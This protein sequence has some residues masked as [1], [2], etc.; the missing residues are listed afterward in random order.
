MRF[1][2]GGALAGAVPAAV[3]SLVF[4]V[5]R[6]TLMFRM[7]LVAVAALVFG[8]IGYSAVREPSPPA[9]GVKFTFIDIQPKANHKLA[10]TLGSLAGNHLAGVP[11]GKQTLGCSVF[12]IGEGLIRVRGRRAPE[13]PEAVRGIAIGGKFDILHILH[14]TMFGSGFELEDGTEIGTYVIRYADKTEERIPII[15]G[16]DVR[17]WW[18]SS[19]LAEPSRGKLAW[20]GKNPAAGETDQIRLYASEWNN[21]YPQKTAAFVDFETKDTVCAPF[22]VALTLER[23]LYPDGNSDVR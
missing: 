20:A 5:Q 3:A 13:P 18:R 22:L 4:Q 7:C 14:S 10:D 16:E 23:T 15:Y 8:A 11:Q 9:S 17:D 21:P 19:D 6:S 1:A 2:T 12:K